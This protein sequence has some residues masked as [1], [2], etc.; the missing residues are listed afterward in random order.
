M[1]VIV[2]QKFWKRNHKEYYKKIRAI[3]ESQGR[4]KEAMQAV[5]ANIRTCER[6]QM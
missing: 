1:M 3:Y 5:Y 6:L 2:L 4:G